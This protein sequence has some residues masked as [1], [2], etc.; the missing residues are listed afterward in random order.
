MSRMVL[1]MLALVVPLG[2]LGMVAG[3]A[4]RDVKPVAVLAVAGY[5]QAM[6]DVAMIGRLTDNPNLGD[7][8]EAIGLLL[9]RGQGIPGLDKERP[10]GAVALTNGSKMAGYVFLPVDDA[11][12]LLDAVGHLTK[13]EPVGDGVHKL[14]TDD[15]PLFVAEKSP[16]WLIASKHRRVIA[17]ADGDPSPIID[18]LTPEYDVAFR[19]FA[20][21][22]PEHHRRGALAKI[23]ADHQRD[24]AQRPGESEHEYLIRKTVGDELV[25][26]I[27]TTV[28]DVDQITLGW[29]LDHEAE[30]ASLELSLTAVP[31]SPTAEALAE[32]EP[33]RSRF[34][35]FAPREA[36]LSMQWAGPM[37]S[38]KREAITAMLKTIRPQ[39]KDQIA[40]EH[41]QQGKSGEETRVAQ[42]LVA[43]VVD[44]IEQTAR[45]DDVDGGAAVLL[46]SDAATVVMGAQVVDV[47]KL[48]D[49]A[50]KITAFAKA[51][52]PELDQLIRLD[53]DRADD[54]RFHTIMLPIDED[55]ENREA[56]VRL[57]GE[58]IEVAVGVGDEALYLAAGRDALAVL[59]QAIADSASAAGDVVEPMRVS[60]GVRPVVDF[61]AQFGDTEEER[62][63]ATAVGEL[64]DQID[65]DAR[66]E[67]IAEAKD[68]GL[69]YR[70]HVSPGVLKLLGRLYV[71]PHLD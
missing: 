8:V 30:D 27:T 17:L 1:S 15:G 59:K 63:K 18:G 37:P 10:C 52:H 7:G 21:N 20:Q 67:L 65:D 53:A 35:G 56:L 38:H 44:V 12:T 31:G 42:Q 48:E 58:Q 32:M 50:R 46:R 64:L 66:L 45:A 47:E 51:E 16:G 60:L 2:G 34:S 41:E 14:Q 5:E 22:I 13:V 39:L 4:N 43:D 69:T 25:G 54:V 70:F 11:G 40:L 68:D 26:L 33:I 23:H 3:S 6:Q 28:E 55:E 24:S 49:W 61:V 71:S 19:V 29:S 57:V 36:A 62:V 9:T